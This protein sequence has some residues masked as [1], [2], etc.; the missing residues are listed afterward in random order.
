MVNY[1]VDYG[2]V[3]ALVAYEGIKRIG[4]VRLREQQTRNVTSLDDC[5]FCVTHFSICNMWGMTARTVNLG[6]V[7][8]HILQDIGSAP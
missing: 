2:P 1:Q 5:N 6:P 3:K 7:L 4:A 8:C